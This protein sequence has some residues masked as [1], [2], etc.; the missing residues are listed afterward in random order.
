MGHTPQTCVFLTDAAFTLATLFF[1]K[2]M[3]SVGFIV[4]LELLAK[5]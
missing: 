5:L 1:L 3:I 2:V 4:T